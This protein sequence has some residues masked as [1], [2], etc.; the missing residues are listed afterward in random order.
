MARFFN[1]AGPCKPD[2]HYFLPPMRRLPEVRRLI[3]RQSYFGLYAPPQSGKTTAL[4]TLAAELTAEWRYAVAL[5]SAEHGAPFGADPGRAEDAILGSFRDDIRA[6]LPPDLQ[7]PPWPAVV[8]GHRVPT[9][10][11]AAEGRERVM[12]TRAWF[13]AWHRKNVEE[14]LQAA[15]QAVV[16]ARQAAERAESELTLQ[17][18]ELRLGRPPTEAE[19]ATLAARLHTLGHER[20]GKVA[21]SFNADATDAWLADPSAT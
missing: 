21:L 18:F 2:R 16:Q 7:P 10:G 14:P 19:R 13:E 6:Q 17:L 12:E 1:T 9:E 20:L 8:A 15:E 3:E 4:L 11:L 5:V